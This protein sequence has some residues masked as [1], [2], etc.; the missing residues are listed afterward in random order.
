MNTIAEVQAAA[1][2]GAARKE[3]RWR[4]GVTVYSTAVGQYK[5]YPGYPE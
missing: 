3:K 5:A 4:G 2:H 1:L